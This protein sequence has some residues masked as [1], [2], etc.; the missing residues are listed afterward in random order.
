MKVL[1]IRF[2]Q[3]GDAILSSVICNSLKKSFPD[4]QV[5][6]VLYDYVAP[7]FKGHPYIDNIIEISKNEAKNPL[8]YLKRVYEITRTKYDIIIDLMG[9]PK[10]EFFTLFSLGSKYRIGRV[11][12]KKRFLRG[13][14]FNRYIFEPKTPLDECCKAL[15][16]LKPLE[17][18]GFKIIYDKKMVVG[19]TEQEV[20]TLREK[21]L[22]SGIDF[23]KPIY[24]FAINSRRKH[25]IYPI[26]NMKIIIEEVLKKYSA[27]VVLFY[28]P[29]EKEFVKEFHKML[30]NNSRIFSNIETKSIKELA[31][32]MK[33]C[34]MFIGN[35][36]GPRH[37]A[38]AVGTP[39]LSIW[40]D[41]GGRDTWIPKDE[42]HIGISTE[43]FGSITPNYQ[44]LDHWEKY[45]LITPEYVLEKIDSM[46]KK[47]NIRK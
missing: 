2:K 25:K 14:V 7:L 13:S 26:E 28:S 36:G 19:L 9:T 3:I 46:I 23:S 21:M 37:L 20:K 15:L 42:N 32:F 40:R 18:A 30:K 17:K 22:N 45:R 43:D 34:D 11:G 35:E 29:E 10:S 5:D 6:Y 44:N 24:V 16:T 4:A 47:S 27:Q 41:G 8:L 33:N 12:V 38:Q 1:V 39:S 31:A